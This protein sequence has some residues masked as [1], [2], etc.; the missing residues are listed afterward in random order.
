MAARTGHDCKSFARRG[1]SPPSWLTGRSYHTAA[2][3]RL[4]SLDGRTRLARLIRIPPRHRGSVKSFPLRTALYL[5]ISSDRQ[6]VENQRPEVEMLAR[7]RGFEI[8]H[9][10]EKQASAAK[11]R[12]EYERMQKDARRGKFG[13]LVIWAIDRFGRSMVG[14]L[15]DVLELD[16]IGGSRSSAAP[17]RSSS[18]NPFVLAGTGHGG[19][20]RLQAHEDARADPKGPPAEPS[21]ASAFR[22]RAKPVATIRK[23]PDSDRE[24]SSRSSERDRRGRRPARFACNPRRG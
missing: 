16:R 3:P 15:Q 14:N 17:R 9:V 21:D 7:A 5:R 20:P 6:S 13:V 11:H 4:C 22:R 19:P 8:V 18:S 12:L 10:Y 2:Y 1:S 23:R 24:S